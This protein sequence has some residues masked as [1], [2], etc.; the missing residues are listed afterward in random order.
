M[1]ERATSLAQRTR[2]AIVEVGGK[3]MTHAVMND[4]A[5]P[6]GVTAGVLYFRG[7]VGAAGD[8]T[9]PAAAA[10]L[11]IFPRPVIE[12]VWRETAAIPPAAATHAYA[13]ACA[14][15]GD[16]HLNGITNP[17]RLAELAEQ[18]LDTTDSSALPLLSAWLEQ[19][20]PQAGPA[21]AAHALMLLRELRGAIHFAALRANGLDIPAAVLLDP[22]GGVPRLQRTAWT[23]DWIATLEH[24]VATVA[25]AQTRWQRAEQL[26]NAT[27]GECLATLANEEQDTLEELLMQ[28]VTTG[29]T[30]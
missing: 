6:F 2:Q 24:R 16:R 12:T 14:T 1:T 25:D 26:T 11:A 30:A 15:W 21:R 22:V 13:A 8:T 23:P 29:A 9:A 27:F 20:R 5:Q 28:T 4:A 10:L 7:R 18:V 19:P 3:F 17:D